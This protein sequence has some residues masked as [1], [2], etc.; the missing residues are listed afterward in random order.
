MSRILPACPKDFQTDLSGIGRFLRE[1]DEFWYRVQ[2][3][4]TLTCRFVAIQH[5]L[6]FLTEIA[7]PVNALKHRPRPRTLSG[8]PTLRLTIII[9]SPT[10][11]I[12]TDLP[13]MLLQS[14][15]ISHALVRISV[16]L[17]NRF[18]KHFCSRSQRNRFSHMIMARSRLRIA[19]SRRLTYLPPL[20]RIW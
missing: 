12:C 15:T 20:T 9:S 2:T 18:L 3:G 19:H 13:G 1:D 5:P 7:P 14:L 6:R 16:S 17:M 10:P 8:P 4:S 11:T